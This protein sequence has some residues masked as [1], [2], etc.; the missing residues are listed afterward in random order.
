MAALTPKDYGKLQT[1]FQRFKDV[2]E[3]GIPEVEETLAEVFGTGKEREA[4]KEAQ[5]WITY[6]KKLQDWIEEREADKEPEVRVL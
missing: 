1:T 5:T 6:W 2:K 3:H 4:K